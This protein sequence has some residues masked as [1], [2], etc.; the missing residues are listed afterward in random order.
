MM[1]RT[2]LSILLPAMLVLAASRSTRAAHPD[3][4][5]VAAQAL[6]TL[7][8]SNDRV[9]RFELENGLTGLVKEDHAA[10]VVSIQI[11]VGSGSIH[12]G[13]YLGAGLSHYI[14]HMIF[15]GTPTR[16]PGEIARTIIGFGGELNAYTSLDRTVFH[17]DL[18]STHWKEALATLAD[19]VINPAFPESEWEKEK[20]VIL[21][22]FSMG[23]D[24]PDRCLNELLFKTAY[25]LH[26][27]RL[28]VIGLKELFK[29]MTREDIVR[30]YRLRYVPDNMV[31]VVVGDVNAAEA[32]AAL[33]Q[34]FAPLVR[35]PDPPVYIPAEPRQ[36]APR[37]LRQSGPYKISRLSVAFHTVPLDDTDTPAL[38]LLAAVV[39][40][41]QSSSLVQ[42]IK[43]QR[44]LVH[45][46][47]ASSF[48]LKDPGLFSIDAS[49]DPRHE[50]ELLSALE[51]SV[52][53]WGEKPFPRSEIDKARRLMLVDQLSNLQGMHGQAASYAEG[54]LFM[55]DPR[56]AESYLARLQSVTPAD[57]QAVARRY[58]RPENRVTVVLGP[59][60][61]P[62]AGT[63]AAA[64]NQPST[65]TRLL[66]PQGIPLLVR[67]DHRLPF[68]YVCAAF[69]GGVLNEDENTAGITALMAELL[70]RG[71]ANRT[72][73]SIARSLE[74]MGAS[75][76]PF[77]GYNSFGV[78]G[79]ALSAD[80]PALMEIL[81]DCLSHP[82]FPTNEV[83]KQKTIQL[84][85]LESRTEQPMHLAADALNAIIFAG[86][87]YRLPQEGTTSSVARL[88][89]ADVQTY[90]RRQLVSGNMTL[91]LFG[92][93]TA[94][95]AQELVAKQAGCIPRNPAAARLG[96]LPAPHLPAR[97]EQR[98]PR[99]QCIVICG[100]PGV[101]I[102]DPRRDALALLE[103]AMSGM[104][105][106]LFETVREKRGLAY[107]A[108]TRQ[109]LG[110]D[111]GVFTLY[112]GTRA[113]ALPTVESLIC[114]EINR[115]TT[116]G[117]EAEEVARAR[118]MLVAEHQMRLQDNAQLAMTCALDDLLGLGYDHEF[119]L[120]RRIEAVTPESIRQA[121]VSILQT[122]RMAVSV[123][124][125]APNR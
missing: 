42:E 45:S 107:Y 101:G 62:A 118:N 28:P 97:I 47:S 59:E 120:P 112:A 65:V 46:I 7:R 105:S 125:P 102:L 94:R 57:L 84:A 2:C 81:F 48:T 3:P 93:I 114:E 115:V 86:H 121:A 13:A 67:E 24:N 6:A 4:D 109:R 30:F 92:D 77:S 33:V 9:V 22:E 124:L 21:R 36:T 31:A 88:Q 63:P 37:Y 41:S 53:R 54:Q 111:C 64:L 85:A 19:A 49:L 23:E 106:H 50:T 73:L 66:L 91:A 70:T 116:R 68:V 69:R 117:L 25:T 55:K 15:K 39:G 95:Q 74:T 110:V 44:Q 32:K 119:T 51:E 35:R 87:P 34:A 80:A 14:E 56:Y 71:T 10:P 17:T 5:D 61:A 100:F 43:E 75:L 90:W 108:S 98:E 72:A 40:G 27:Y 99:E 60:T 79:R 1:P 82:L 123:V 103:A 104:S 16:K 8:Q 18:P 11:W 113:E 83:E 58:L 38:D 20:Q 96:A 26:P 122:N 78:Q 12:E 29:A 76:T 52:T 89:P